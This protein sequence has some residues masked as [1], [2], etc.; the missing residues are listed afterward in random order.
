MDPRSGSGRQRWTLERRRKEPSLYDEWLNQEKPQQAP[1]P[2]PFRRDSEALLP[3]RQGST[4][5]VPFSAAGQRES[6]GTIRAVTPAESTDGDQSQDERAI[7]PEHETT[8][9][10]RAFLPASSASSAAVPASPGPAATGPVV[11]DRAWERD[12][13][14]GPTSPPSSRNGSRVLRTLTRRSSKNNGPPASS[15]VAVG[16]R[17]AYD[18]ARPRTRTLEDRT[19]REHSPSASTPVVK[20]RN[21]LGSVPTSSPPNYQGAEYLT[22]V[23]AA[24]SP[25]SAPSIASLGMA[26]QS[27]G[28]DVSGRPSTSGDSSDT[29]VSLPSQLPSSS[30]RRITHLMKTLNGQMGG[31][32]QFRRGSST[33]WNQSY[34]Y[35]NEDSASLLYESKNN[36]GAHRT[37]VPE[38]RGCFVRPYTESDIPYLEVTSPHSDLD[39]HIK[40]LTQADFEAWFAILLYWQSIDRNMEHS[41]AEIASSESIEEGTTASPPEPPPRLSS[42]RHRERN[43]SRSERQQ[44]VAHPTKEAPVIKIGKMIFW[45]TNIRYTNTATTITPV[46]QITATRPPAHRTH[47]YATRRWQRISGQLRENGELKLH[48]DADNTLISVVQL[49]QL[50]RCAIQRLDPSVLEND[51]CIA[52][53]PQYTSTGNDDQPNLHRPMFLS[54]ESRVLYEVWFVLLRAFTIPQ[55]YGPSSAA[56][57][58]QNG[59]S[60]KEG[61]EEPV[62]TTTTDMFRVERSLNIRIIEAKMYAATAGGAAPE[63]V[64]NLGRNAPA[65]GKSEKHGHYAEVLLDDETRARTT[66]KFEAPTP[67]W[68]ESFEFL[69]LPPV[70]T[71][72]NVVIKRRPPDGAITRDQPD[73]KPSPEA[74]GLTGDYNGGYTNLTFDTTVGKVEIY[75]QE[76]EADKEVE[77]WW[78][79]TTAAGYHVGDCL[80]RARADEGVILMAYDYQPLSD[81]LHQFSNGLTLQIANLVN[82]DLKRLS[83]CLLNIYQVSGAASNWLMSLAED[84]IDGIHKESAM[85]RL[86]FNRRLGSNEPSDPVNGSPSTDREQIV[87]DLNRN[88]TLEANLLFRGNTLLTKSL[89]THMRRVG[90]EYLEESLAAIMNQI[91]EKDPDCEVDPNRVTSPQDLDRNWRRLLLFTQEVWKAIV[92]ARAKCPLEL[93]VIFR[94]IRACAED[95]YGDFLRSVSY[96]SVSGFLFLRFFCPAVLNPKLFGLLKGNQP[97]ARHS[98]AVSTNP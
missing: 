87:R 91:N 4:T 26:M 55:L 64:A 20:N 85:Q 83:D 39:V 19:R 68:A 47:S 51:F 24:T 34:C 37:L 62:V 18:M 88:A 63:S 29:A 57:G 50:S 86:R 42:A 6:S 48:A 17:D 67:L 97:F 98:F 60:D 89:D 49:S 72:A 77:K 56:E 14:V 2:P 92:G 23:P 8:S 71:S 10:E 32:V 46:G 13:P 36:D 11:H 93:R 38:L 1:T 44:S 43:G 16:G 31:T 74:Y 9:F 75:L 66:V 5:S 27:P 65:A 40:V 95:R 52:I 79:I 35:V 54:L 22:S 73:S 80:I 59:E 90:K 70:L 33:T 41:D 82:S 3:L 96:S 45:D 58:P 12:V 28:G 61:L 21:R 78:P 81:L 94:H 76:L 84:E 7:V 69:D 53:Y 15:F 30:A 25:P